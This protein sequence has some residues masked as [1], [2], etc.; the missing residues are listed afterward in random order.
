[1]RAQA[2]ALAKHAGLVG[3][4][5]SV[6]CTTPHN[7]RAWGQA[8][9]KARGLGIE[10]RRVGQVCIIFSAWLSNIKCK[11]R[12]GSDNKSRMPDNSATR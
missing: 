2:T 6:A 9:A 8:R 12:H 7:Y 1:M 4:G 10:L 5:I 3:L 11:D